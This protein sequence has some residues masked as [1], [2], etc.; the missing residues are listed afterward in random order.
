MLTQRLDAFA[1]FT[2]RDAVRLVL[3]AGVLVAVLTAILGADILPQESLLLAP[4]DLAP[5]DIKAPKAV[6]FES[7]FRT[8]AERVAV[9]AAVEPQTTSR[10]RTPGAIAMAQQ[11]AFERR[12]S[13]VDTTFAADL[14]D[15]Q[16]K[17]LLE[18][19]VPTCPTT[20]APRSS[21]WSPV[22]RAIVR[23]YPRG[24]STRCCGRKLLDTAVAE[25]GPVWPA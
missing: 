6:E 12:V 17:S 4:G 3:A 18:T 16:R 13:R 7:P 21:P 9:A 8:Q 23:T 20:S 14:P 5:R 22:G 19:A 10:P 1:R 24:C 15:D 11:L 25:P 2:R